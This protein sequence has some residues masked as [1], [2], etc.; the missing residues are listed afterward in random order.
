LIF[1]VGLLAAKPNEQNLR[2]AQ[3]RSNLI[4]GQ[5]WG[6]FN[7]TAPKAFATKAQHRVDDP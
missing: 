6:N 3:S 5:K 2:F 7:L 1:K 4:D